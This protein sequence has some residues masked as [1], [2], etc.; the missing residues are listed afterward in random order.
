ML[1]RTG[2]TFEAT[3]PMESLILG[4]AGVNFKVKDPCRGG[5]RS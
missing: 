3:H 1:A 4:T 5:Q 2:T